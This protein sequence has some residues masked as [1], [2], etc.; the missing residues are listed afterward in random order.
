MSVSISTGEQAQHLIAHQLARLRSGLPQVLKDNDPEPL[1]QF[2][3]SLRRLRSV[4]SQFGSA[5]ELPPR[6]NRG[7]IAALA[8][9]TG[10]CRDADVLQELLSQGL[11][12]RLEQTE[13]QDC[14]PLLRRLKRQR[15]HAF[16]ELD[17][18]LRSKRCRTL[19]D[20][21]ESWTVAPRFT[22]LGQRPLDVWLQ[23]WVLACCGGCF[24]HSGWFAEDPCD[25]QLHALR[26]RIKEVRYGLE[27]LRDWLGDAGERWI[28]DLRHVQS[29]LGDLHDQEVLMQLIHGHGQGAAALRGAL[30]QDRQERWQDWQ[31]LR[32][33]LLQPQRRHSLL[34]LAAAGASVPAPVLA[35][36][37]PVPTRADPGV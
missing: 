22:S 24:L 35:E 15:R 19:L 7:R 23:E 30:E 32:A 25:P 12:P 31:Q 10:N 5:L 26:K 34:Q 16:R 28:S 21:L 14:R 11:L 6:L 13:R 9:A 29:C 1:H 27:A 17:A 4:I 8:R 18:G 2:R 3:V 37:A 33:E 20:Q 36:P